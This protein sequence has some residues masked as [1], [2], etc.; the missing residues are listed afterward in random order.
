[1]CRKNIVF[2]V[3]NVIEFYVEYLR[4]EKQV[5]NTLVL[6]EVNIIKEKIVK[7]LAAVYIYIVYTNNLKNY[8]I[9]LDIKNILMKTAKILPF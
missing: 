3:F 8:L 9:N 4:G 6:N 5:E 1:M 7:T 2:N